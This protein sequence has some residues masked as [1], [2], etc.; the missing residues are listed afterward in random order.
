MCAHP[1]APHVSII[2]DTTGASRAEAWISG[3]TGDRRVKFCGAHADYILVTLRHGRP[4]GST[5]ASF[6]ITATGNAVAVEGKIRRKVDD[7][8]KGHRNG[9][10]VFIDE[11]AAARRSR[12]RSV[13]FSCLLVEP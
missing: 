7:A 3:T 13:V 5:D 11:F 6:T 10:D 8:S 1:S 2:V 4:A 9:V 12:A